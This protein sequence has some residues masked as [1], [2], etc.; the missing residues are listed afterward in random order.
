MNKIASD[1]PVPLRLIALEMAHA[2][3]FYDLVNDDEVRSFFEHFCNTK[4]D[5]LAR[6]PDKAT[7]P[8]N[9]EYWLIAEGDAIVAYATIKK[10]TTIY[11]ALHPE[12]E[13]DVDDPEFL[14]AFDRTQEQQQSFDIAKEAEKKRLAP[15]AVDI[16]V[17]RGYRK[18]GIALRAFELLAELAKARGVDEVYLEVHRDN[19]ASGKM[20]QKLRSELVATNDRFYYPSSI[21]RYPISF[22]KTER[23]FRSFWREL[24]S[25]VPE[26]QP[27]L[28]LLREWFYSMSTAFVV[29]RFNKETTL[30]KLGQELQYQNR[31]FSLQIGV[32]KRDDP[33]TLIWSLFH[34]FGHFCQPE[35]TEAEMRDNT[36][37]KYEREADAWRIAEEKL[38]GELFYQENKHSFEHY[39][40]EALKS[41]LVQP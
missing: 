36:Q 23:Q 40:N 25:F 7:E 11:D 21:Y 39:R 18:R 37:E 24:L 6:M 28:E 33:L 5:I 41:Y 10:N 35:P 12:P 30:C 13:L 29:N 19:E 17:H 38:S 27:H 2:E 16:I 14:A 8:D 3:A 15:F 22:L 32:A 20:V 31:M 26:L 4:E 9:Q 1:R 34:E